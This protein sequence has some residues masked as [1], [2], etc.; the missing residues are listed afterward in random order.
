MPLIVFEPLHEAPLALDVPGGGRLLDICDEGK[1][2]VPFSCRSASCGTCRVEI[3]EG[4]ELLEA[5]AEDEVDLLHV[6]GD[7]PARYRLACQARV[8]AGAGRLRV[9]PPTEW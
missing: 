9:R 6:L 7:D 3:V 8:R 2:P 5:P 1:A 4:A